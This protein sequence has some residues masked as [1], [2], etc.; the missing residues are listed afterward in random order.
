MRFSVSDYHRI[1]EVTALGANRRIQLLDGHIYEMS[2]IGSYHA[3]CVRRLNRLFS[4]L[5]SP[6]QAL[7]SVQNPVG[8]PPDS[9]PEPDVALL[10]PRADDYATRH[11][12]AEEVLLVVE[13][14]DS[15]LTFDQEVKVPIYAQAGIPLVWVVAL[16]EDRIYTYQAPDSTTYQTQRVCTGND[17]LPL[18]HIGAAASISA[19][20]VFP[21]S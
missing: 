16:N 1:A 18:P 19:D 5:C 21:A 8:L 17:T 15:S 14:A 11:P 2:P 20:Q 3:A 13:V 10:Q 4:A 9:E 6:D 7:V 12:R